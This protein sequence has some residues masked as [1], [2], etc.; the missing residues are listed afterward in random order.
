VKA[1]H[2]PGHT[3]E[4]T[5]Y[6]I[7]DEQG[8][9]TGLISGDT[10]FIGDVGRPD[11]A[12][13]VIADLTQDKL[14]GMLY[15][16]LRNKIM[17][18][19]DDVIIYPN[20]GAGSACGKNM[21]KETKDTLGNQKKVNYALNLNLSEDEFKRQLLDGLTAPPGYFPSNVLMNIKGYSSFDDVLKKSMKPLTIDEFEHLIEFEKVLIL[22]TRKADDFSLGFIPSSIN[23]G[24][25]GNF[26]QWVGEVIKNVNQ[27]MLLV[28]DEGK[29]LEAITR[30][31][32]IGFD[33]VQGYLKGGF[34][35]WKNS[36]KPIDKVNRISAQELEDMYEQ[37]PLIFDVRKAS[38]FDSKHIINSENTPL[39]QLHQYFAQFPKATP[40]IVICAGGYRSM[41]AASILKQNGWHQ[42]TDVEGGFAAVEKT[43]IPCTK[44]I[45]PTTML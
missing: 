44:F 40:F 1:I 13:H 34:E 22:D 25:E 19:N 27:K 35:T 28:T 2:T 14:A 45:C 10:L 5:V 17:P 41:I 15:H 20:H 6:L 37:H 12:Q 23:I 26:A 9:E 4:S 39:N 21:S 8:K 43:S 29:E 42:F 32:R 3:L 33:S 36:L 18:L 16:S 11:L 31:S 38:E 30:L 7:H 24:L